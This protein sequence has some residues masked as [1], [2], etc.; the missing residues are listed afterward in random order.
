MIEI[1]LSLFFLIFYTLFAGSLLTIYLFGNRFKDFEIYEISFFGIIFLT[2]ISFGIHLFFPLNEYSILLLFLILFILVFINFKKIYQ[3]L[4]LI[5]FNFFI[6]SFF[7]VF[8]MTLKYNLN[9]DYGYYH[10]PYIINLISEKIIF[11]LSHLQVN[12]AWN[13]TWL[14]FSSMLNFPILGLKGTQLSNSILF[15]FI[16]YFFLNESFLKKNIGKFSH[17][18]LILFAVYIIIKFSRLKEHGF[19]FPANIFLILAFYYFVK[20]FEEK[21]IMLI[22][23]YFLNLT[24]FSIFSITIKLSTF[25]SPILILTS[26][27]FLKKRGIKLNLIDSSLLFIY[28]LVVFW[29][30]QQFIYTGCISPFFKF[31]CIETLSWHHENISNLVGGATGAVNK[32]FNQYTGILTREEYVQNFNW[33]NTWFNRNKVEFFEHLIALLIPFLILLI[34]NFR[35]NFKSK[36]QKLFKILELKLFIISVFIFILAGIS[37][38]FFKSPVIRFGIPYLLILFIF[39][40]LILFKITQLDYIKFKKGL[41]TIFIIAFIFNVS[42]NLKRI[43][44]TEHTLFWPKIITFNY[45]TNIINDFQINFPNS[46][47]N[48][49]QEKYCWSIPFICHMSGGRNLSFQK[50]NSYI[51]IS[52]LKKK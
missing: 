39:L 35:L 43:N 41:V 10:L 45:G 12:F 30:L 8:I 21:N 38:W 37:I 52:K 7:V 44:D 26:F 18:F 2:F 49:H 47:S 9:E 42:K 22:R 36:T 32:S 4:K 48:F 33:V 17:S 29:C 23:R 19:D 3:I 25:A 40:F 46:E 15:F 20:I 31:S 6:I 16:I 28:F 34:I 11:G 14:N 50:K 51:F 27:L 1:F 24:Y 5:N 13:S